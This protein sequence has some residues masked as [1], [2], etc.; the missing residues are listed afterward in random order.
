[1]SDLQLGGPPPRT[2]RC[3]RDLMTSIGRVLTGRLSVDDTE[4]RLIHSLQALPYA[5]HLLPVGGLGYGDGWARWAGPCH[6]EDL[7]ESRKRLGHT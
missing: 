2:V 4:K 5:I 6:A 3:V 1:M 7:Q